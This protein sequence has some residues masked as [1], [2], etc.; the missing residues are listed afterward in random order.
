MKDLKSELFHYT[1]GRFLQAARL[2]ELSRVFDIPGLFGII[3]KA[4]NRQ[5]KE[6]V[7]FQKLGEGGLNRSFLVT[8][9][10]GFQLVARIPYPL[11]TPRA[12][13][14]ASEVAT[15]DFLR[16]KGVP[17]PQI[18]DYSFTSENEAG[19]EYILM[20]YAEGTDLSDI[21]F[22]LKEDKIIS[23]MDQLAKIESIVMSI[24]FPVGGS[25]YYSQDLKKLSGSEG[26][27][28]EERFCIGP[29]V[30]ISLWYGRREE[31]DVFRGPYKDAE[32]VLVTGAKKELAYL[33]LFGS[34]R[35]A[36]KGFRRECYNFEKQKPSDHANNLDR[37]LLLAP[38]LV[39]DDGSL[40]TFCIR[41]PDLH[42]GNLR[43]SVDSTS[44]QILSVLD[45][46][47]A[48]VLPLFLHAG[49]PDEIQN[50]EDEVSRSMAEP[51]LPD[52]FNELSE[53]KQQWEMELLRRR[54]VHYHYVISTMAYNKV[55]LKGLAYPMNPFCRR[56]FVH[57]T[58]P[59]EGET[60]K[61]L[62]ALI[63]MVASWES[64]TTDNTPCPVAFTKDEIVAAMKLNEAL[65]DAD[66]NERAL[67]KLV[68]Y[69]PETWVPVAYYEE[70][71]AS[72]QEV[73]RKALEAFSE[74]E[75]A[76][77]EETW[78][79]NDMDEAELREYL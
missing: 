37:Y 51:Q 23:L 79:L 2:R 69:G 10:D 15:M 32:S 44:L 60:I 68:G 76:R 74:D 53:G 24:S 35:A 77:A 25:I 47:H 61:L 70:A 40:R 42:T 9:E 29:D 26:V 30:S 75:R 31:L 13:S 72:S 8:L 36:Y 11:L 1:T 63:E 65:A 50:E 46:Q 62:W 14:Y 49:M 38:S 5:T 66:K 18:Y 59:W 16:S 54:L 4:L 19:T 3:A 73:K 7:G 58:A 67:R 64:F 33:E 28:L 45:W 71:M 52:G 17:I 20:Q 78:P 57:A 27:P 43:V 55:H 22:E 34:P 39:P 21:W 41:H 56:I 6:I 48:A 12:Y